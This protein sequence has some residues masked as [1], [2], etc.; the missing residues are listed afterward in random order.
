MAIKYNLRENSLVK[1]GD[2]N[3]LYPKPVI[4]GTKY[5]EDIIK[6]MAASASFTPG[7]IRG[8]LEEL[9]NY[10]ERNLLNGYNVKIDNLGTFSVTLKS[11][12]ISEKNEVRSQSI[13]L[14]SMKF[15]PT[16]D[17]IKT[18]KSKSHFERTRI[19]FHSS[20]QKY[21]REERKE[22]LMKHLDN[23]GNISNM[24]Y[25]EL[26]GLLPSTSLRELN[27]FV[28]NNIIIKRGRYAIARYYKINS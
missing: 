25:A 15:R 1:E 21:T 23:N 8:V 17:V 18:L 16:V 13:E 28:S 24:E 4:S 3:R 14:D 20:S 19:G 27:Y 6:E 22:M 12:P 10:I 5:T 2:E 9:G 26:T 7:V 11:R